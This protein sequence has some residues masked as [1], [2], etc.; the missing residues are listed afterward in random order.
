MKSC[1]RFLNVCDER[2]LIFLIDVICSDLI[3]SYDEDSIAHYNRFSYCSRLIIICL[4]S[5]LYYYRLSLYSNVVVSKSS[6]ISHSLYDFLHDDEKIL[7]WYFFEFLFFAFVDDEDDNIVKTQLRLRRCRD[8]SY[9]ERLSCFVLC[10]E[11]RFAELQHRCRVARE[12]DFNDDSLF[13]TMKWR[14]NKFELMM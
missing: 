11:E 9:F 2:V 3:Y 6:Y 13:Q 5:R 14:L 10:L 1:I 8:F 12:S 4:K 7:V